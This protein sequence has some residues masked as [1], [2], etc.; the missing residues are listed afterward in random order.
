[1]RTITNEKELEAAVYGGAFLGGDGGG[2]IEEGIRL[3]KVALE[4]GGVRIADP[5]ELFVV[6][7]STVGSQAKGKGVLKPYNY[8]E[9]IR[10]VKRELGELSGLISSENGGLNTVA[11][12][13]QVAAL[14][15]P[16]V[17]APCDGRAH[18]TILMGSMGL[19]RVEGYVSLQSFS[20]G[21]AE[22]N[23]VSGLIKGCLLY[24]SPSP[25]DLSTSRMPSSA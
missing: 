3:G 21:S 16:V 17:D 13:F 14:G 23:H 19:H 7:A 9:A 24:T 12:W 18:P 4:I 1:M 15:L 10:I 2:L 11:A 8:I 6:T 5:K 25:R 20:V 22:K